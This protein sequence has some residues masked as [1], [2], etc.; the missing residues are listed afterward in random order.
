MTPVQ[1]NDRQEISARRSAPEATKRLFGR[2]IVA[3]ASKGLGESHQGE[4]RVWLGSWGGADSHQGTK[5]PPS[6]PSN[7]A[8]KQTPTQPEQASQDTEERTLALH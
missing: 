2:R 5:R 4:A 3:W 7:R 1:L 8:S 6:V